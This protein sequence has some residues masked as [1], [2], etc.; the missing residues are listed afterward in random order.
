MIVPRKGNDQIGY[1]ADIPEGLEYKEISQN[2]DGTYTVTGV[3]YIKGVPVSIT[4]FQGKEQLRNINKYD[5]VIATIDA[6]I[7]GGDPL[8]PRYKNAF[9]TIPYWR[10]NS[11]TIQN[12]A[13][14]IG[15]VGADL[16]NFFIEA[17]Q[18]ELP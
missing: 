11:E 4:S 7:S 9:D 14:S 18:I 15:I 8:G 12:M 5:Q 3:E 1:S 6:M 10:R 17:K 16:D 2:E 13:A